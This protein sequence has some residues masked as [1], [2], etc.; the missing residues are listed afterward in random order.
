[1]AE[2]LLVVLVG[3]WRGVV[4]LEVAWVEM[5]RAEVARAE[6]A[7]ARVARAEVARV[8]VVAMWGSSARRGTG[9]TADLDRIV[10]SSTNAPASHQVG[11][12]AARTIGLRT[13]NEPGNFFAMLFRI[14][15]AINIFGDFLYPLFKAGFRV[16][17]VVSLIW[18][19]DLAC[20]DNLEDFGFSFGTACVSYNFWDVI[21]SVTGIIEACNTLEL[22]ARPDIFE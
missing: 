7:R 14:F 5:A 2:P 6:V 12:S 22:Q 13:I 8:V 19:W 15:W 10:N 3:C 1:M 17:L 18:S 4:G 16:T 9:E 20:F 11:P 21:V